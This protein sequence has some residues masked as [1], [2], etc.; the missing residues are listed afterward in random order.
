VLKPGLQNGSVG[1]CG[2]CKRWSYWEV[3][4]PSRAL[5]SKEI[6]VILVGPWLILK[7]GRYRRA[8]LAPL[9]SGSLAGILSCHV[10]SP[11][12]SRLDVI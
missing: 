6:G 8:G 5:V 7:R 12:C 10:I 2:T 1:R 11:F 9:G 3:I 4:R